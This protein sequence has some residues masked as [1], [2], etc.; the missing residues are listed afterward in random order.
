LSSL[1]GGTHFVTAGRDGRVIVWELKEFKKV[2]EYRGPEGPW[3]MVV[4]P[5]NKSL[6]MAQ[7]GVI[8]RIDLPAIVKREP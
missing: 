8:Q 2:K 4:S 7:P 5:E 1:Y 3:R 6:V